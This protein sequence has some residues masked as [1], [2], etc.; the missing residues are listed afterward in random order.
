[1]YQHK[2]D[3]T[4]EEHLIREGTAVHEG[5]AADLTGDDK[6]DMVGK[7]NTIWQGDANSVCFRSL[8]LT[9]SP[10]ETLNVTGP[11]TLS[12]RDLAERFANRFETDVTFEGEEQE[13]ALLNDA[14][15]SH[16]LY[17]E[18]K[19]SV[20]DIVELVASWVESE[21]PKFHVRSGEF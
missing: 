6:P 16:D 1:M 14:S 9:D 18:P 11:E 10:A 15:W 13:T 12:V 19:V 5:K 2:G 3:G 8:E 17:G 20:D 21:R 4:F 7:S